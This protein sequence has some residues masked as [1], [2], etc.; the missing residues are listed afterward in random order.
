MRIRRGLGRTEV[1]IGAAVVGV[2]GL[3]AV[4]L[5][6]SVGKSSSR[7]EVPL[8]VESIR[9]AEFLHHEPFGEYVAAQ[10]APRGPTA[11]N[12]QAVPWASNAGFTALGW[13][14][15]AQG[16]TDVYGSY[17]VSVTDGGFKVT[18]TC[19]VDADGERATY[20]ATA[21]DEAHAVTPGTVY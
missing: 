5:F 17:H 9:K 16:L 12:D 4:P 11:V 14:P 2:L 3:I 19:D 6:L 15:E 1:L 13:S 7:E 10:P 18:G 21:E 20:E 8:L